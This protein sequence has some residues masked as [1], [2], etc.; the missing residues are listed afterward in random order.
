MVRLQKQDKGSGKHDFT[1]HKIIATFCLP[2]R[3]VR[4]ETPR[5]IRTRVL[6]SKTEISTACC[7]F[8]VMMG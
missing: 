5:E 1:T 7:V 2:S 8:L 3:R 6:F 4:C